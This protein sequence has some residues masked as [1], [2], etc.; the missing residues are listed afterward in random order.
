MAP[1]LK[2]FMMLSTDSTSSMGIDSPCLKSSRPRSVEMFF[3]RSS[4]SS[5]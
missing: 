3:A 1:V 2:R 4:M 5:A